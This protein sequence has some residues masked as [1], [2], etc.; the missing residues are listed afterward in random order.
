MKG[1]VDEAMVSRKGGQT[2]F[3]IFF[4]FRVYIKNYKSHFKGEFYE[5]F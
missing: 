2:V 5:V 4:S 3:Q 1:G